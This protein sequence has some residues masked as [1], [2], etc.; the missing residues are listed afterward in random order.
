MPDPT[1][2]PAL[3]VARVRDDLVVLDLARGAYGMAT[4]LFA[5]ARS[6]ETAHARVEALVEGCP[7]AAAA[8]LGGPADGLDRP[9]LRAL[10]PAAPPCARDVYDF[11]RAWATL[12]RTYPGAPVRRLVGAAPAARAAADLRETLR[13]A[14]AFAA[15]LPWAPWPGA[16]LQ[17]AY[18]LRL[19]LRRGG[20][21][22]DWVFGVRT[23]PFRAHCW[24]EAEGVV[25][26]DDPALIRAY[27]PILRG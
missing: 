14:S 8:S 25:L 1:L 2:S 22:A 12:V 10:D 5:G 24:L 9:W 6:A 17:R 20:C 11:A 19:F 7:F 27:S 21:D 23:W 4:G 18:L 15:L 3:R 13:R 26:N 16:C